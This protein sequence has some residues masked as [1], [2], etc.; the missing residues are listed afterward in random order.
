MAVYE[1]GENRQ[2]KIRQMSPKIIPGL[3]YDE[4]I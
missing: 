1:F 4:A 3:T 2:R